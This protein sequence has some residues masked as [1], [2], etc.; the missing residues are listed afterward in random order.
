MMAALAVE[1]WA[2]PPAPIRGRTSNRLSFPPRLGGNLTTAAAPS[3]GAVL[4]F[5]RVIGSVLGPLIG[6]VL[7]LGIFGV[8]KPERFLTHGNLV[9]VCKSNYHFAIAAVGATFVII[10]AGI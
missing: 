8:W 3:A 2:P 10:T 7:V 9:N 1:H 6:L 4:L 5:Q